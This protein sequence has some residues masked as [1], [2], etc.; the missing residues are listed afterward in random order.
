MDGCAGALVLVRDSSYVYLRLIAPPSWTILWE[1]ELYEG[2]AFT[3]DTDT[4]YSFESDERW[5]GANFADAD[6]AVEFVAIVFENSPHATGSGKKRS[7]PAKMAPDVSSIKSAG[8]EKSR[9]SLSK[10]FSFLKLKISRPASNEPASNVKPK[11][12]QGDELTVEDVGEPTNFCHLSHIGFDASRGAFDVRNIPPE[13]RRM[14]EKAG[15]TEK[16]LKNPETAK[17]IAGF[18]DG[19]RRQAPPP[20]PARAGKKAP[21]PPPP[22][23]SKPPLPS[24][25]SAIASSAPTADSGRGQLLASIR[26]TGVDSLKK[27]DPDAQSKKSANED[28]IT[29]CDPN[30]IMASMLAKALADRNRRIAASDS[31]D[32]GS[33]WQ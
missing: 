23:R 7:S 16:H 17:F 28:S 11:D 2:F 31:E 20:V 19:K 8:S 12:R 15:V 22:S 33:A 18:V 4:F 26:S 6:E 9:S 27:A 5:I 24:R 29:A 21:P 25:S 10:A 14:F 13:W 3:Q 32:E 1:H 30:D